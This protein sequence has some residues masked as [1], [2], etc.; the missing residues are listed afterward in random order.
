MTELVETWRELEAQFRQNANHGRELCAYFH[1]AAD[2]QAY[3]D[4]L[5]AY[6]RSLEANSAAPPAQIEAYKVQVKLLE[7]YLKKPPHQIGE[8][9]LSGGPKDDRDCAALLTLFESLA[10]RSAIHA[11]AVNPGT[12]ADSAV[13]EWLH[14]IRRE[15]PDQLSMGH[16]IENV[17]QASALTCHVMQTRALNTPKATPSETL[18]KYMAD[19]HLTAEALAELASLAVRSVNR[20]LETGKMSESS[21]NT[22]ARLFTKLLTRSITPDEFL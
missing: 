18:R 9:T 17:W 6:G 22:Y 1:S 3:A 16:V 13:D 14:V 21:R 19:C 11:N 2:L 5:D 7:E 15:L 4:R 12:T 8:W 20:H 10:V